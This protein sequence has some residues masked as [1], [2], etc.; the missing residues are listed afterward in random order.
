M[1]K[2]LLNHITD[3]EFKL[4]GINASVEA[5]K[6]VFLINRNLKTSFARTPQD[7][8]LI[9][10]GHSI[11]FSLF[12][13]TD[14]KTACKLYFVQNKSKYK[15]QNPKFVRSLFDDEEQEVNKYLISSLKQCDYLIKI[16][17]EFNRCKIKKMLHSLN[18]IPQIIS[19]YEIKTE[20]I[21][22]PHYLIFE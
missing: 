19:A 15:D 16:E 20:D 7:V 4:I 8:E 10:K 6:I 14:Q 22:T 21:K 18:D 5:Y 17:D 9:H 3:I 1:H 12:T 13:F 11:S 2:L